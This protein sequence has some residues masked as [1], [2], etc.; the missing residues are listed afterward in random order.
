[1]YMY[2]VALPKLLYLCRVGRRYEAQ[3]PLGGAAEVG[4][5]WR[6]VSSGEPAERGR[7]GVSYAAVR[8]YSSSV[9]D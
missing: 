8:P 3:R 2:V 6:A 9:V 5:E 4:G 7:R 1:M